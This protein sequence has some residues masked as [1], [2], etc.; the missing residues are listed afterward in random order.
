MYNAYKDQPAYGV[1]V[2]GGVY[3]KLQC[4]Q[5]GNLDWDGNGVIEFRD[6]YAGSASTSNLDTFYTQYV[7]YKTYPQSYHYYYPDSNCD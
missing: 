1:Y 6:L 4:G 5:P 2:E 3:H 7:V